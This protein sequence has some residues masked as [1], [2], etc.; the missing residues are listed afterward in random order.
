MPKVEDFLMKK[1]PDVIVPSPETTVH[2]AAKMM[3]EANVGSVIIKSSDK[4]EGIFTERDLL[5]KVVTPGKD[6]AETTLADVMSSPVLTTSLDTDAA[7]LPVIFRDKH[8]RH[9]A[10]TEEDALVGMI[11]GRD[12]LALCLT[13]DE[14]DE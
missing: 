3:C 6:P 10:V 8:I 13:D 4:I 5:R 14:Q 1:G 12:L 7:T 2:E 11:S 9:L